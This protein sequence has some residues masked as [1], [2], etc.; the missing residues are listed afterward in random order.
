MPCWRIFRVGGD[1]ADD[2]SACG[3]C[4]GGGSEDLVARERCDHAEVRAAEATRS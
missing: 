2:G 1:G 3:Q 4:A